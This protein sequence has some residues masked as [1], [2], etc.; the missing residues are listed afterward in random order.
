MGVW[1]EEMG[2]AQE[3]R[4]RRGPHLPFYGETFTEPESRCRWPEAEREGR[5]CVL[6]GAASELQGDEGLEPASPHYEFGLDS[7]NRDPQN[8][9]STLCPT[10]SAA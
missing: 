10:N 8:N 4:R 7:R 6:M 2:Q 1:D 5:G 3:L 9:V